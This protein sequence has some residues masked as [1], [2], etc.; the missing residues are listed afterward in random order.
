M[1][2]GN[3]ELTEFVDEAVWLEHHVNIAG[4]IGVVV[5]QDRLDERRVGDPC[6]YRKLHPDV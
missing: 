3:L 1:G 5:S 2:G 6:P 4:A